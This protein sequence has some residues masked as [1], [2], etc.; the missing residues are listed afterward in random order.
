MKKVTIINGWSD[1]NTG[2]SSIIISMIEQAKKNCKNIEVNIISELND[3]NEFFD[4]SI[5]FIKNSYQ[6]TKINLIGSVFFKNYKNTI[7]NKI[8]EI[9]SLIKNGLI[10]LLPNKIFN[11]LTK[12]NI[13][14]NSLKDSDVVMSKGGHFI[15][16]RGGIKGVIHLFKCLYPMLVC[17]KLQKEY[18]I[19]S[20][21]IGPLSN[22]GLFSK[23]SLK[24]CKKVFENAYAISLREEISYKYLKSLNLENK[25]IYLTSD[26]AF[27]LETPK[28]IK[29]STELEKIISKGKFIVITI[30]Q[31]KFSKTD[32]KE[33]YLKT[34]NE[35]SSY[36]KEKYNYNIVFFPHVQ[37]PNN[38]E[39]DKIIVQEF[40]EEFDKNSNKYLYINSFYSPQ[41]IKEFYG[42]A[43]LMIGTRF[44]SVIFALSKDIPAI[45]ISYSGYKA[46]IMNQVE[47]K[48]FM[49]KIEDIR[50]ENLDK[51]K[52]MVDDLIINK[53]Y[54][55]EKIINNRK[56]INKNI[57]NDTA[58]NNVIMKGR[59]I[60]K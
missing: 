7:I 25:N 5:D 22:R 9:F 27:L 42:K 19:I 21:S 56:I 12:K 39:N 49:I 30:R 57:N 50:M 3:K 8:K 59:N 2:D 13:Y 54:Y 58:F 20:Q 10:I 34:I 36:I 24:M 4:G 23:I 51:M 16:D 44:H 41:E 15:H 11:I 46:F 55:Q 29:L 35:I 52:K 48:D 40:R 18:A 47:M 43:E 45:A 60:E 53:N 28:N 14:Y 6:N 33:Q 17:I 32:G 31:H 37:G 38:F 1:L 26:Y